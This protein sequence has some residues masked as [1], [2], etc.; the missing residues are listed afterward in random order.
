MRFQLFCLL[1]FCFQALCEE[2]LS[3]VELKGSYYLSEPAEEL[4][5]RNYLS[6]FG[7]LQYEKQKNNFLFKASGLAEAFSDKS[8]YFNVP[9]LYVSYAY[10]FKEGRFLESI[11]VYAG[12]HIKEWSQ[13]DI[14]WELGAWNSLNHW[15]PLYPI[16]NGLVGAF[17]DLKA[18]NWL[19]EFYVGAIHLPHTGP[20]REQDPKTG[21]I[22]SPSRW[23]WIPPKKVVL[24]GGLKWDIDY[25]VDFFIEKLIHDSYALSLKTW[26]P[27]NKDIWLKGS[28]GYKQNNSVFL[29]QNTSDRMR[30][31][32]S[33]KKETRIQQ[34]IENHPVIQRTLTGELGIKHKGF[35]SLFSISQ[36]KLKPLKGLPENHKL[37][38]P[39]FDHTY[40][41]ALTGYEISLYENIKTKL[42]LAY[43]HSLDRKQKWIK[44]REKPHKLFRGFRLDLTTEVL[45]ATGLKREF[46]LK[47]WLSPDKWENLFSLDAFMYILPSWYVAG[48]ANILTGKKNSDESFFSEFQSNDYVSGRIGFAF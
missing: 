34:S 17:L 14:Y 2:P 10:D 13:A 5:S 27:G 19:L 23:A 8:F 30:V 22:S 7:H 15:E 32:D 33:A 9:E 43:L 12:R 29:T 6:L 46:S 48:R 35:S 40:L 41:S 16:P 39:P 24:P 11:K 26:L 18:S 37:L 38:R 4:Q 47:F 44:A 45:S 31:P 42:Q 28:F 36:N 21:V 1:F 25:L 20:K 3:Q